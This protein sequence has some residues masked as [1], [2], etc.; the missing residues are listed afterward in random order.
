MFGLGHDGDRLP[1]GQ[2]PSMGTFRG[3]AAAAAE[4]DC[5]VPVRAARESATE[6][7]SG[8]VTAQRARIAI[9]DIDVDAG[10]LSS[11]VIRS[12]A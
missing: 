12:R 4:L 2:D 5:P 11:A 3:P 8:D 10:F 6:P 1:V 9:V 7:Q